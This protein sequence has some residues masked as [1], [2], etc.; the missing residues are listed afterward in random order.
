MKFVDPKG[1]V[2]RNKRI[3]R[4]QTT[5]KLAKKAY[6]SFGNRRNSCFLYVAEATKREL[7]KKVLVDTEDL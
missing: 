5:P 6:L 1:Q 7:R 3:I 2:H 4:R